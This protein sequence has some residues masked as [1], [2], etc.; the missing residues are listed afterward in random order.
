MP[1]GPST[2]ETGRPLALVK[3]AGDLATG[4]GLRLHRAGF[5]VVMTE[6]AAP[7]VVRRTVA[8]AEAVWD[9]EAQ[10]EGV[11][12]VRVVTA[13]EVRQALARRRI[14][15]LVDPDATVRLELLPLVLVDAIVAKRNLGTRLTDAPAVIALGPGFVA[16]VEK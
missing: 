10:V 13:A 7:T 12:G 9:G 15:V 6:I 5:D 14:P 1:S 4:V 3:G 11:T 8:F 16:G 2:L